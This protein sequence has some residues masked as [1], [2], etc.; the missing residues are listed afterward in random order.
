MI[1]ETN[2]LP[3]PKDGAL[4]LSVVETEQVDRTLRFAAE[5]IVDPDDGIAGSEAHLIAHLI[6]M[7][8]EHYANQTSVLEL[9]KLI[10]AMA[11]QIDRMDKHVPATGRALSL[12]G[13]VGATTKAIPSGHGLILD[14]DDENLVDQSNEMLFDRAVGEMCEVG[15][16]DEKLDAYTLYHHL[17]ELTV[18]DRRLRYVVEK[19]I[20]ADLIDALVHLGAEV[21]LDEKSTDIEMRVTTNV[22]MN[23][24]WDIAN[25]VRHK[26]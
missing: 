19:H 18:V 20:P 12:D 17:G 9:G 6:D 3:R 2:I 14:L 5:V 21:I 10:K 22:R 8:P 11:E 4:H 26:Q 23:A 1:T 7:T 15:E 24:D 16:S 25:I 13:L